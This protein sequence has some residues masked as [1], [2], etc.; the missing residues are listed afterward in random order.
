MEWL[1]IGRGLA[2]YALAPFRRFRA[3]AAGGTVAARYCH[4]VYL[5]H[6]DA[7]QRAGMTAAPKTIAELGP[8]L[9]LGTGL[10]GLLLGAERYLALD[11]S[12][13]ASP[14]RNLGVLAELSDLLASGV[15]P[16]DDRA[17]PDVVP[18]LGDRVLP[19]PAAPSDLM[20]RRRRITAT[21]QGAASG[22]DGAMVEYRVPWDDPSVISAGTVDWVFSQAVLEHVEDLDH[23][24]ASVAKWLR[25]GGYLTSSVDFRSHALTQAWNGHWGYP[26]PVWALVKGRRTWGINR[27]IWADHEAAMARAGLELLVLDRDRRPSALTREALAPRFRRMSDDDLTTHGAFFTARRTR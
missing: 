15:A 8:G 1:P 14:E 6:L 24:Y 11:V 26:D 5:R 10:M 2:T 25:P 3:A 21:L 16:A 12:R 23:V 18:H 4:T 27:S 22:N 7:A 13:D 17:F 19:A 9:S 20:E